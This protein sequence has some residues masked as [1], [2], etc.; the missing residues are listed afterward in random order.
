MTDRAQWALVGGVVLLLGGGVAAMSRFVGAELRPVTVGADAP[1]FRARTLD[2]SSRLKS[3][4]DYRGQVVLLNIWATWCLPCRVEMPS[5]EQLHQAY[6]GDGLRVV[7]VSV[8][9]DGKEEAIRAFAREYG[10]SFEIL[11]D[12][13]GQIERQYQSVGL[14]ET[15][16]IGRDGVIRRKVLGATTWSSD[17][18]RALIAQLL[19]EGDR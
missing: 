5:I 9:T 12:P 15:Y 11:H 13:S 16:V 14:P 2:D 6:A 18:N 1:V 10:L 7:A 17:R 4:E 3:F 19:A 8:D